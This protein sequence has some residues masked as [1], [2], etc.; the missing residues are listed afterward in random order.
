[1][2]L[3]DLLDGGFRVIRTKPR[4]VFGIAAAILFPLAL[5][6]NALR[7]E[8][9]GWTATISAAVVG[10]LSPWLLGG[11][12]A[13]LLTAWYAGRDLGARDALAASGR[14][15]WPLLGADLLLL[16]VKAIALVACGLPILFVAPLFVLSAPA[17]VVERLGPV[18]GPKRSVT[19]V[20]RRYWWVVLDVLVASVVIGGAAAGMN[21]VAET[22]AHTLANPLRWMVEGTLVAAFGMV[23]QTALVSI[24]VLIYLDL[25]VRTE[26]LDLE[27]GAAD[28]FGHAG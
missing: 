15:F 3:A 8:L 9:H 7:E 2:T 16:P 11:A 1:M 13:A 28:A 10:S 17:V 24:A 6:S 18:A 19:L 4:T 23:F 27:L 12:L 14:R 26:G 22:L 25:R 21:F 20:S 5:V